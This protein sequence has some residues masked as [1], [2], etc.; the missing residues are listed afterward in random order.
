MAGAVS[1]AVMAAGVPEFRRAVWAGAAVS[2]GAGLLVESININSLIGWSSSIAASSISPLLVLGIWWPGF[3]R[4]G[5][6]GAV[7]VGGGL[8]TLA[9]LAT[10]FGLVDGG[11]GTA[12]LGTPALWTVPLA[13]LTGIVASKRDP[14]IVPDLGHK[15]ALMHLPERQDPSP[16][17]GSQP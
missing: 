1:H 11:W 9:S 2:I 14:E 6:F 3:T 7:L 17:T 4:R 5:A 10:M 13:F 12:L 16:S 15:F 8:S